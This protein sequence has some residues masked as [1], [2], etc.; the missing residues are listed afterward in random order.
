MSAPTTAV[1]L[2]ATVHRMAGERDV[3]KRALL[4]EQINNTIRGILAMQAQYLALL[5]R[6]EAAGVTEI[7]VQSDE[8]LSLP[9]EEASSD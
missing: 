7:L 5:Q 4:A 3:K 6:L 1:Q 9:S 2:Y 8:P